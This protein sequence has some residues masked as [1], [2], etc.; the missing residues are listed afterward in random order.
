MQGDFAEFIVPPRHVFAKAEAGSRRNV[1]KSK[2]FSVVKVTRPE[3]P[4][5]WKP[6]LVIGN[7]KSGNNDGSAFLNSFRGQLNPLQV[8]DL[9]QSKMEDALR[10]CQA[11]ADGCG[12]GSGDG[13]AVPKC[14][15]LVAGG[16]GTIGWTLNTIDALRLDPEPIIALLPLGTGN[17]LARTLGYGAGGDHNDVR[18]ESPAI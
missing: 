3:R 5:S 8:V 6:L 18:Y 16:D 10:L 15:V 1:A 9:G 17:D 11:V 2:K 12:N 7:S 4:A 13:A 14:I